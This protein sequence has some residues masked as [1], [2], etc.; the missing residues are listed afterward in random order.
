MI[1]ATSF[2]DTSKRIF[3]Y[4]GNGKSRK[5]VWLNSVHLDE[6]IREVLIGFYAF[7]GNDYVSSFF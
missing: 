3:V 5:G 6:N 2:L 7:T 1:I 4:Y